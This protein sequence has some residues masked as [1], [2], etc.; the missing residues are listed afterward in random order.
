MPGR[1][2]PRF[3]VEAIFL[4]V[5]AVG[6]ALADQK[7]RTI[8]IVMAAAWVIVACFE[9][10]TWRETSRYLDR[11][12]YAWRADRLAPPWPEERRVD[13]YAQIVV[14]ATEQPVREEP[15]AL[16]AI[17]APPRRR[18]LGLRRGRADDGDAE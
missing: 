9:W 10:L 18:W 17:V 11:G 8:V 13:P 1:L 14:P 4:I 12:P 5:L 7:P 3:V 16:T 6:L 2:G 15:E